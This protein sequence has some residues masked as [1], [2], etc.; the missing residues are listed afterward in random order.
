MTTRVD[1]SLALDLKKFGKGEW[2]ECFHCGK[3]LNFN[4]NR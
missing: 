4:G 2:N 3:E 1:P